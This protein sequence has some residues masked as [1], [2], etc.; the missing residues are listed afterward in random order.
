M[1]AFGGVEHFMRQLPGVLIAEVGYC[2]GTID[3]PS[4]EQV[5]TGQTGH[6]EAIRIIFDKTKTNFDAIIRLF[7][8]IHD[9]TQ[10]NSQGPDIGAQYHSAIFYY[11]EPQFLIA[12][13][14]MEQLK[15]KG[16]NVATTLN[17]ASAFWKAEDYHQQY[18]AKH[19]KLPY[20]HRFT[21]RI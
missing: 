17:K 7:F 8:N 9:P 11:D 16:L 10:S 4:Y 18:Y 15:Q 14:L 3:E 5:C 12:S 13:S 19:Q 2:G 20:C 6:L 21:K 1:V